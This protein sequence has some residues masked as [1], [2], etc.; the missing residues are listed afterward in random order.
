MGVI[1][2]NFI[3]RKLLILLAVAALMC[4][5]GHRSKYADEAK[6]LAEESAAVLVATDHSDTLAL[7]RAILE[8][9]AKQ[10]KYSLLGDSVAVK[11][12]E[13]AFE[14][15]LRDN[16]EALARELF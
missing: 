4:G 2:N 7:Q 14:Q 13:E 9:K 6:A 5:C 8:A 1:N 3:M 12:F 10:G 11:I 16:D 15:Y